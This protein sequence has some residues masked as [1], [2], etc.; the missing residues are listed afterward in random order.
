[1]LYIVGFFALVPGA[2]IVGPRLADAIAARSG[3]EVLRGLALLLGCWVCLLL[4]AVKLSG[5][6]PWGDGVGTVLVV[7]G[8]GGA[9]AAAV[10]WRAAR[11]PVAPLR[12]LAGRE[13]WLAGALAALVFAACSPCPTSTGWRSSRW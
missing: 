10:L 11:V 13:L 9:L 7:F 3:P 2:A 5:G 1:M 12:A 4:L 6:L 8:V